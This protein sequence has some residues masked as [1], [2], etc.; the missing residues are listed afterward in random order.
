MLL[1]KHR[2]T[3]LI[4]FAIIFYLVGTIG[5]SVPEYRPLFLPLSA[6]NL[7][8]TLILLVLGRESRLGEFLFFLLLCFFV[9][10]FVEW[11]GVHTGWLFGNY[12]YGENLGLKILDIPVVIGMNWGVLIVTS[13]EV[14]S[15]F[16]LSKIT[17]VLLASGLMTGLDFLIE[18]V[19][20]LSDYWSWVGPI[21]VFN[22]IC[23]FFI[24]LPLHY[25]YFSREMNESNKT[26]FSL[27]LILV[28]FFA[29][30]NLV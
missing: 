2:S 25:N 20:I 4:S 23:W 6:L 24:A 13:A 29:I 15:R 11:L 10:L 17:S 3:L 9:G 30:Q 8:I 19:A 27:F 18:P 26:H 12:S 5:L 22:Y 14:I 28:V 1:Q 21:P 16:R 7:I